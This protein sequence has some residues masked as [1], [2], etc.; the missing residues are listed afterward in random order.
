ML[1]RYSEKR[2]ES[3]GQ[4]AAGS[5][6]K[7]QS[8]H[9][10]TFQF[11]DNRPKAVAQK[12]LQMGV[13][14]SA[15]KMQLSHFYDA[16]NMGATQLAT[17]N[18]SSEIVQRVVEKKLSAT[19][20]DVV[21]KADE[22]LHETG[23]VA[24]E[25]PGE[26]TAVEAVV[27]ASGPGVI[28]GTPDEVLDEL[29]H[30][31]AVDSHVEEAAAAGA[32]DHGGE[33]LPA[34]PFSSKLPAIKYWDTQESHHRATE[35][36]MV[37]FNERWKSK[38]KPRG[39]GNAI[40]IESAIEHLE[41]NKRFFS[42]ELSRDFLPFAIAQGGV[43]SG[44]NT[45]KAL[46]IPPRRDGGR[47]ENK[48][49]FTRQLPPVKTK[50]TLNTGQVGANANAMI[51]FKPSMFEDPDQLAL[52]KG[53]DGGFKAHTVPPQEFKAAH[54]KSK[55]DEIERSPDVNYQA[56]QEQAVLGNIALKHI[57]IIILKE[58]T[59]DPAELKAREKAFISRLKATPVATQ[60][61]PPAARGRIGRDLQKYADWKKEQADDSLYTL[62][63]K[64]TNKEPED[65]IKA[66]FSGTKRSEVSEMAH[67]AL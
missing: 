54:I 21:V 60:M 1:K 25:V 43:Q 41:Q 8:S 29:V 31:S 53:I 36:A 26:I 48:F 56:N 14:N 28:T 62:L 61:P 30:D 22:A 42:H 46:H 27:Q 19:T 52:F 3:K 34:K 39:I 11:E 17:A 44:Y 58:D 57:A 32:G 67:S 2:S 4:A 65:I 66:V 5:L 47:A 50:S 23:A 51:V 49:V 9:K 7:Q 63:Q 18:Q 24:S 37:P 16:A 10:S 13:S 15:E 45:N 40:P 20:D 64:S 35:K 55:S 6:P 38:D 59:R 12:K 33:A